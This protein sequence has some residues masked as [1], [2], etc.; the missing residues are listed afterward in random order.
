[1]EYGIQILSLDIGINFVI[2]PG[3][4]FRMFYSFIKFIYNLIKIKGLP[5]KEV[6]F[7]FNGQGDSSNEYFDLW[8]SPFQLCFL[9][10]YF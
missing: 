6:Y 8:L 5:N 2:Y 3:N 1:M 10:S 7:Q 9:G 4:F